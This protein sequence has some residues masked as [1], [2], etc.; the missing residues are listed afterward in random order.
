M[1]TRNRT[2]NRIFLLLMVVGVIATDLKVLGIKEN[3][4]RVLWVVVFSA[5]G[6]ATVILYVFIERRED[7][8]KKHD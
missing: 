5:L 7:A 3:P 2:L 8:R 6:L 1:P 4:H